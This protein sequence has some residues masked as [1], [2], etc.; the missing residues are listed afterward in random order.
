[1][2]MIG[3]VVVTHGQLGRDLLDTSRFIS[4][5]VEGIVSVSVDPS[6]RIEDV[7]EEIRAAIARVDRGGGVLVVTDMF[8]G[9][10]CN[11]SLSFQKEGRIE[12]LCGVNLPMF[13]KLTTVKDTMELTELALFLK[14]YGQKNISLAREIVGGKKNVPH[15]Q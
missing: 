9:T 14:S 1:M 2:T 6:R 3:V 7:R 12:V 4:G 15:P 10:P 5:P 8:G 13:L 11:L